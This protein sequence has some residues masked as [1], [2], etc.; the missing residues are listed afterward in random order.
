MPDRRMTFAEADLASQRMAKRM[1]ASGVGKGTRVGLFFTYGPEFVV[2]WLAAT[3][4]GALAMPLSTTCRPS[5]LHR[6]LRLG[7]VDTLI[8]PFDLLG[9]DIPSYLES[10]ISG[11]GE[12][13]RQPFFLAELPYLRSVWL[14]DRMGERQST[15]PEWALSVD[16]AG[17]TD[18]AISDDFLVALESEVLS[19][20]LAVVVYTS[21][22]SGEPKGVV[23]THGA[24]LRDTA[25]MA[26]LQRETAENNGF[27]PRPFCAFPFFW[28]GG[29]LCLAAAI[30]GGFPLLC[31]E[32]FS[33]EQA[34]DLIERE[35]GT[36]VLGWPTLVS[37]MRGH[38]SFARRNLETAPALVS[39]PADLALVDAVVPGIPF[40]RGMSETMGQHQLI[41][42]RAIDPDS[43]TE[44][45]DMEEGELV[46]RGPGLMVGYYKKEH[47]EVFDA[48]GWFHTG[49]RVFM[50]DGRAS[51][52]GR[53][54][55]M[56]K[57]QGA[58]VAPREV[59]L[60]LEEF[61]EV[62]HAFVVGLPSHER[63]EEVAAVLVPSDGLVI[64]TKEILQRARQV[65]SSYKVPTRVEVWPK[66]DVPWLPS[67]KPDKLAI[68]R[69]LDTV[70][71]DMGQVPTV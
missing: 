46:V 44:V 64:E 2:T 10:A 12:L 43:G 37:A 35:H 34:L 39:A 9:R 25:A 62:L 48:N 23:H 63:G 67:N 1:L 30:Q 71:G 57:S 60:A 26:R 18:V 42:E 40:H 58:N 11:L 65:L 8:A 51:F 3:R 54:T 70:P 33:P 56:I 27:E 69:A 14:V 16:A 41:E 28:V 20:D 32:R 49:D 17:E 4:I 21:G 47:H 68:R 38:H 19:A 13:V 50:R 7:D 55:E 5:E 6:L 52:V 45:D 36:S 53:Y 15:V 24:V 61:P 29:I 66:E 31:L 22:S 59:E